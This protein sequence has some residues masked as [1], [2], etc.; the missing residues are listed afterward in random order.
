MEE[1]EN[2]IDAIALEKTNKIIPEN[3]KK[4]VQIFNIIGTYEGID[5]SDATATASDI[6]KDKTAYVN[7]EKVTGEVEVVDKGVWGQT[8]TGNLFTYS[9]DQQNLECTLMFNAD[10]LIRA[11]CGVLMRSPVSEFCKAFGITADKIKAGETILGV[12]GTYTGE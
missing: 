9:S 8:S 10:K 7:K 1:L 3:I 4:D 5:T 12:T 6:V 2:N 11:G